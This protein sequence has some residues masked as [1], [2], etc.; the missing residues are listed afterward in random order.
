WNGPKALPSRYDSPIKPRGDRSYGTPSRSEDTKSQAVAPVGVKR[1]LE[2]KEHKELTSKVRS[3]SSPTMIQCYAS[4]HISSEHKRKLR[5]LTSCPMIDKLFITRKYIFL[6]FSS[7]QDDNRTLDRLTKSK[8][9]ALLEAK[10]TVQ[11][12]MAKAS[13]V[14]DFQNKNQQLIKQIE[15]CQ[16]EEELQLAKTTITTLKE[17]S[18]AF[19]ALMRTKRVTV[20]QRQETD[21]SFQVDS[22]CC[23][24]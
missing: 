4:T 17:E 24:N 18:S 9:D 11:I 7:I 8:E 2:C 14:D 16:V 22:K 23:E 15:I 10:K 1:K 20:H 13:L 6:V 19:P 21:N 5:S 3:T 12:A